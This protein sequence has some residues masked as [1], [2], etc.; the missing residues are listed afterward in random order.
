M[1]MLASDGFGVFLNK[2]IWLDINGKAQ[3]FDG[4]ATHPVV[5]ESIA[6]W[7]S[8]PDKAARLLDMLYIHGISLY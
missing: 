8:N 4:L 5:R 3:E 7:A 6:E 2:H 1:S